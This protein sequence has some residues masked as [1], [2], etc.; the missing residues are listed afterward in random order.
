ML[1]RRPPNWGPFPPASGLGR[2]IRR[3]VRAGTERAA[4]GHD[5]PAT[6]LAGVRAPSSARC[7]LSK[8]LID[9]PEQIGAL[10]LAPLKRQ[11]AAHAGRGVKSVWTGLGFCVSASGQGLP[12]RRHAGY[13]RSTFHCGR[14]RAAISDFQ[15]NPSFRT[16][17]TGSW[18][19]GS[20]PIPEVS[21]RAAPPPFGRLSVQEIVLVDHASCPWRIRKLRRDWHLEQ[22]ATM[23][24][25]SVVGKHSMGRRRFAR[26]FS[27]STA[28]E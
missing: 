3:R 14:S 7:S 17:P 28:I 15:L 10:R 11:A 26:S 13:G 8:I 6:E 24:P 20:V 23:V 1:A 25:P 19:G 27:R 21:I 16:N 2:I 9:R 4:L 5:A 22:T 12:C 18:D